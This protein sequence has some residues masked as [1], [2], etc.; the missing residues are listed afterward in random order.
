MSVVGPKAPARR[1]RDVSALEKG[2]EKIGA[3]ME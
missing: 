3:P 1:W 2:S